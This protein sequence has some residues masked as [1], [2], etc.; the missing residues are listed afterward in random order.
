MPQAKTRPS[1]RRLHVHPLLYLGI[2]MLAML[3]LWVVGQWL[4]NWWQHHQDYS[5][6]G[7]PRTWQTDAVVGH[8]GDAKEN[9]SHFIF[10]N[11]NAR[12]EVIE[13][14]AGDATKAKIY[15]G[16]TLL[17]DGGDLIPVTGGFADVNGDGKPDM[18]IKIQ[19]QRIVFMNTGDGFRPLQQG[20]HVTLPQH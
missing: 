16:P 11:L 18:I 2:G 5:T 14:P 4:A 19:D 20:E 10:L 8:N 17:S 7:Y 9:P 15:I 1:R 13:F 12:V 3:A 6:Y